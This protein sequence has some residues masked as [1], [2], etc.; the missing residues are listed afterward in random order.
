MA[1]QLSE[2]ILWRLV[3]LI[4]HPVVIPIRRI[5][6]VAESLLDESLDLFQRQFFRQLG[7]LTSH[8]QTPM[9]RDIVCHLHPLCCRRHDLLRGV[10]ESEVVIGISGL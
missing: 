2:I 1:C 5:P 9:M 4:Q 6:F 10:K 8:A 3:H 7:R